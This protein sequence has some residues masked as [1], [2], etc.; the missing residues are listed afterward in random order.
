MPENSYSSDQPI[1]SKSEDRFDRW[2]FAQRVADTL[3]KRND[4]GSLVVGIYGQWGD[5]KTSVLRMMEEALKDVDDIVVVK[6]NPW[7]FRSEGQLID[8]FFHSVAD[9][10]DKQLKTTGEKIG[11]TL[12]K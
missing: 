7:Y 1:S 3:G 12:K 9:A 2:P 4:R 10:L 6:F 5:G 11:E 8:G